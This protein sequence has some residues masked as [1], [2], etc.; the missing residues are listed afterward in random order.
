MT[1]TA[2]APRQQLI[3]ELLAAG[4]RTMRELAE[5]C[6]YEAGDPAGSRYVRVAITRHNRRAP[7][8]DRIVNARKAGSHGGA[9]YM[10]GARRCQ[11]PGCITVLSDSNR[12][13]YCRRHLVLHVSAIDL[14]IDALTWDVGDEAEAPGQ[15]SLLEVAS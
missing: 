9:I 15:L 2:T 10:L 4:P 8:Q 7:R 11:H 13:L 6:G 5:A 14:L 12:T 1:A 3:L